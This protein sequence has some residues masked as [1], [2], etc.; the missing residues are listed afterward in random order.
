LGRQLQILKVPDK[1]LI[2]P[3]CGDHKS[4]KLRLKISQYRREPG[5]V[6]Q[7]LQGVGGIKGDGWIMVCGMDV[8]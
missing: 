5:Y 8:S 1:G 3:E 6:F 2:H 7:F 4:D